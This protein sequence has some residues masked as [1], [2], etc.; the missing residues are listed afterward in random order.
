MAVNRRNFLLGS[1]GVGAL[2]VGVGAWL[3]PGDRGGP[4]SDYFRALNRELK[5]HGTMR[6]VMLIDLDRLDH[7]IDV[8]MQSVQRAGKHL[9]LVEK[10]LPA[11][12]LLTYIAKRAGTQRLMSFHQPFPQ[13]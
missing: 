10:S 7:N 11:P 13:P 6:P 12:G 5:D 4:Y 2:L 1:V 9:R 8:V 3:R